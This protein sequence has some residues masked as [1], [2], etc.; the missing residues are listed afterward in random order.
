MAYQFPNRAREILEEFQQRHARAEKE[1][2]FVRL[3]L[4]DL[5]RELA[6]LA[7]CQ[8]RGPRLLERDDPLCP[9]CFIRNGDE[10]LMEPEN[11]LDRF[12]CRYCRESVTDDPL[13][14][15]EQD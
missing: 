13:V 10:C 1:L 5:E 9:R 12:T 8:S 14:G 6:A 3:Q 4:A 11:G 2:Q 7:E 15:E